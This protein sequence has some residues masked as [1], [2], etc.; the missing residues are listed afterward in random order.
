[1]LQR[2]L[3]IVS[4]LLLV[5]FPSGAQPVASSEPLQHHVFR[6]NV[7]NRRVVLEL[8]AP[9]R[10]AAETTMKSTLKAMKA[11]AKKLETFK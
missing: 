2:I 5:S 1:M 4:M 3:L 9:S 8:Y 6:K 7:D 11:R 10:R